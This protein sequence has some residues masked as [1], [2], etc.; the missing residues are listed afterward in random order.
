MLVSSAP[1]S[2]QKYDLREIELYP[3]AASRQPT[4]EVTAA[5]SAPL[6]FGESKD[7]PD[8]QF[9]YSAIRKAKFL[10]L[11]SHPDVGF[12][13]HPPLGSPR[14][15]ISMVSGSIHHTDQSLRFVSRKLRLV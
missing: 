13:E 3:D 14:F 9:I 1:S 8:Q 4:F 7:R 15:A 12:Q 6:L 5:C 10:S 11:P 2:I